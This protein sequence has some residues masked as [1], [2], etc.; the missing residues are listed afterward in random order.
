MREVLSSLFV[1]ILF[2]AAAAVSSSA[3]PPAPSASS[4]KAPPSVVN[5]N[6][7]TLEQLTSL[8]GIGPS[9]AQRI[10]E[11]RQKNGPFKKIEDLMSVKGIGEKSFLRLK[12]FLSVAPAKP[13]RPVTQGD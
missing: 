3:Q 1:A 8:P 10:L 9:A 11:Y 12:S 7:A 5:L 4:P 2:V 13:E 6:S